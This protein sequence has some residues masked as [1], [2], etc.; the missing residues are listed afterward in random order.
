MSVY[1]DDP[2][3]VPAARWRYE[4]AE[5]CAERA[6]FL[7]KERVGGLARFFLSIPSRGDGEEGKTT[8]VVSWSTYP[9]NES[10]LYVF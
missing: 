7:E 6:F 10:T 5:K 9:T 1:L 3:I 4:Q 2:S 8:C